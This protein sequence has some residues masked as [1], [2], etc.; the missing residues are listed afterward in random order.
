MQRVTTSERFF[1]N[2]GRSS[3]ALSQLSPWKTS[4]TTVLTRFQ[5]PPRHTAETIQIGL[6]AAAILHVG[7]V[8]EDLA[9][10]G[11]LGI[12]RVDRQRRRQPDRH[13]GRGDGRIADELAAR[14]R[15]V[16]HG[17]ISCKG[18]LKEGS[19]RQHSASDA[20]SLAATLSSAMKVRTDLLPVDGP[21]YVD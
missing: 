1:S 16:Y 8:V 18:G 7:V 3:F 15:L 21:S 4:G 20:S 12:G 11:L 14:N 19:E 17:Q 5:C 9:R 10:V 6:A 2:S 13:A